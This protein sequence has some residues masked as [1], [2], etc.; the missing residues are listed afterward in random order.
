MPSAS[1]P[2]TS[3]LDFN[4]KPSSPGS[5]NTY[6]PSP[7]NVITT[8][9]E[10]YEA[11]SH[12]P[13]S[14]SIVQGDHDTLLDALS[15]FDLYS[16][17]ISDIPID[18]T[19]FIDIVETDPVSVS[20]SSITAVEAPSTAVLRPDVAVANVR[21]T[22]GLVAA[23]RRFIN[24]I[25]DAI[26][27]LISAVANEFRQNPLLTFL[28]LAL[29][30]YLLSHLFLVRGYGHGGGGHGHSSGGGGYGHRR[31]GHSGDMVDPYDEGEK[32]QQLVDLLDKYQQRYGDINFH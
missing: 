13:S 5:A 25:G 28:A 8:K 24:E 6:R 12:L 29:L 23:F 32:V 10:P 14:T 26:S 1:L 2:A 17:S 20:T 11:A 15:L 22:T 31:M 4:L 18:R 16:D 9:Y 7:S 21:F 3:F 30:A 19:E 27:D